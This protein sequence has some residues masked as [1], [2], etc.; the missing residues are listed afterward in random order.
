[1]SNRSCLLYLA[2]L[3]ALLGLAGAGLWSLVRRLP[4]PSGWAQPILEGLGPTLDSAEAQLGQRL[5]EDLR[6]EQPVLEDSAAQQALHSLCNKLCIANGIEPE[7]LYRHLVRS[8]QVNAMALPGRRLVVY[9]G[10]VQEAQNPDEVAGVLAHEIAHIQEGHVRQKVLK[11]AGLQMVMLWVFGDATAGGLH[12]VAGLL[13]STAFDRHLEG[14]ADRRAVEYLQ[15]ARMNP[16]GLA[17]FMDRLAQNESQ[18]PAPTEWFSTHPASATRA[19]SIRQHA[20]PPVPGLYQSSLDPVAWQAL[21]K[22]TRPEPTNR[23]PSSPKSSAP[24]P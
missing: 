13:G 2:L 6:R 14:R 1:M 10:L 11:Q 15:K 3:L 9:S 12:Q 17:T 20:G 21:Q 22:A 8:P 18:G 19:Q 23:Q 24:K 7:S 16:E 4:N 5:W